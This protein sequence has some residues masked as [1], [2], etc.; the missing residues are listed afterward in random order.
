M[1]R[2]AQIGD[3]ILE[4]QRRLGLPNPENL[5]PG[6]TDE[7]LADC[8]LLR[9][10][11]LGSELHDLYRW[12]NG[13]K[14]HIPMGK[15]W[16]VPGH[17]FLSAHESV[18]SNRYLADHVEDWKPEWYPIMTNGSSDLHFVD[19][20]KID[21]RRVPVFDRDPE[22]SPGLWR[23]YDDLETMF[24]S[25]LKCYDAGAYFVGED[26][27]L[28]SDA[29]REAAICGGLNPQSEHWRRTDLFRA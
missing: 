9:D 12:R 27:F 6:L 18:L 16:M 24:R 21:G 19:K 14:P 22:F 10:V 11:P 8:P 15:L 23:I 13:S 25:I 29:R 3:E 28:R 4:V 5:S 7:A 2:M 26:G 17:Y 1:N 20:A